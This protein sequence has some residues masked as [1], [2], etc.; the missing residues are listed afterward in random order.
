MCVEPALLRRRDHIRSPID[1]HHRRSR[2]G[3]L[4]GEHTVA[5]SE[6]EDALARLWLKQLEHGL[7][8]RWHEMRVLRVTV[9]L[10]FVRRF[11]LCSHRFSEIL[12]VRAEASFRSTFS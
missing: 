7:P 11:V 2:R 4:F 5:A 8:Q 10:P 12:I 3:Y 1:A 6:V 9:S